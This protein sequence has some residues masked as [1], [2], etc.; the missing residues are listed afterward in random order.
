MYGGGRGKRLPG[1]VRRARERGQNLS[2]AHAPARRLYEA[3]ETRELEKFGTVD[4][5][6]NR[7]LSGL[8]RDE[9]FSPFASSR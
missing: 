1:D 7:R 9:C 4:R 8:W 2:L 5:V 6:A 3:A